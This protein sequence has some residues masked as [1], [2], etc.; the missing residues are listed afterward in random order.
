[1]ECAPAHL[2]HAGQK[3]ESWHILITPPSSTVQSPVSAFW[4]LSSIPFAVARILAA[5]SGVVLE[6]WLGPGAGS[7]GIAAKRTGAGVACGVGTNWMGAGAGG[8]AWSDG[9]AG[10]K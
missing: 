2:A 3:K 7:A 4:T 10:T 1:M 5:S 8:A 6:G 9:W